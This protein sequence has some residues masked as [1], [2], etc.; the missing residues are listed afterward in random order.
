MRLSQITTVANLSPASA[1]LAPSLSSELIQSLFDVLTGATD[2]Q[3]G[4][5]NAGTG[6]LSTRG[7]TAV[8]PHPSHSSWNIGAAAQGTSETLRPGSSTV[9]TWPATWGKQEDV[10]LAICGFIVSS[11]SRMTPRSLTAPRIQSCDL[12]YAAVDRRRRWTAN[13]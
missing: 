6:Y 12:W 7:A 4:A 9:T 3:A 2:C 1:Y 13:I 10:T 5:V 8:G 11:A